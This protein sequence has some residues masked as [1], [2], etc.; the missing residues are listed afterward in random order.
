[1]A[2]LRSIGDVDNESL[3]DAVTLSQF[4]TRS[5]VSMQSQ[6]LADLIICELRSNVLLAAR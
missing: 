6:N 3:R 4:S 1:M 5:S 2:P